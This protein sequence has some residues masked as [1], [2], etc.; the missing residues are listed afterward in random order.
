MF[1]VT[2][3]ENGYYTGIFSTVGFMD[4]GIEVETLP[5]IYASD[6]ETLSY[7]LNENNEW[8]LDNNKLEELKAEQKKEEDRPLIES[9]IENLKQKL[10]DSDYKI[11]KCYE[12]LLLDQDPPYDVEALNAERQ[13][14]RDE[15]N[16]LEEQLK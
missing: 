6:M 8:E 2:L 14:W 15:I 3:D 5:D 10:A 4:D 12:A 7:K 9:Q 13:Q 1:T 11:T 16:K